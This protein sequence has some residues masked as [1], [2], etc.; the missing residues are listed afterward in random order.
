MGTERALVAGAGGLTGRFLVNKLL[1]DDYFSEVKVLSTGNSNYPEHEK[2]KIVRVN[3]ADLTAAQEQME[4]EHWFCC[5]GT[6]LK[7]AGSVEA[8]RQVDL[9]YVVNLGRIARFS[10]NNFMVISSVGAAAGSS[11]YYLKAKGEMEKTLMGLK[12]PALHIFRPGLLLGARN[13]SR[14]G[15]QWAI[16]L[17]RFLGFLLPGKYKS[18]K[19]EVLAE[20]ML[21]VSK[22]ADKGIYTYQSSDI[23]QL[24]KGSMSGSS[25]LEIPK[26][27]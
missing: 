16:R 11:N 4:A 20:T 12:L 14:K 19:V 15:E 5:L 9:N 27:I 22:S 26:G 2:L 6:T 21:R 10:C 17:N 3:Y 24:A 23:I 1:E 25:W 7:K 13:E 8:F 18:V